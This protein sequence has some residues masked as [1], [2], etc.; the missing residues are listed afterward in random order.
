MARATAS[1]LKFQRS[2]MLPPPRVTTITS[3]RGPPDCALSIERRHGRRNF[4]MRA[5][6]LDADGK[7]EDADPRRAAAENVE[8]VAH[9]RP[10]PAM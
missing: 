8:H 5:L 7:Y 1:S 4:K 2:S 3:G 10:L 6:A 9:R